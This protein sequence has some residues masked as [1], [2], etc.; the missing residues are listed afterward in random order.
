MLLIIIYNSLTIYPNAK[1]TV[2]TDMNPYAGPN[3]NK[4]Q[5]TRIPNYVLKWRKLCSDNPEKMQQLIRW[6]YEK[7]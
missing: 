6:K 2:S 3:V 1:M 7:M 5:I 4:E